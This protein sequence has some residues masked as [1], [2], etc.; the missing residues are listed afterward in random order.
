LLGRSL[1]GMQRRGLIDPAVHAEAV[2]PAIIGVCL[3]HAWQRYLF[4]PEREGK[5]PGLAQTIDA[6]AGLLEARRGSGGPHPVTTDAPPGPEAVPPNLAGRELAD[7]PAN[8]EP[9]SGYELPG[10]IAGRQGARSLTPPTKARQ[11][12]PFNLCSGFAAGLRSM[13]ASRLCPRSVPQTE[14]NSPTT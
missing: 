9:R 10:Q 11:P 8:R 7:S 5:L 4:G 1:A 2:A 13:P 6:I 12:P 14:L 3:L